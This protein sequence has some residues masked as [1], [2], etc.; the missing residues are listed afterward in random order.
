METASK[1]ENKADQ[2]KQQVFYR[3]ICP[4]YG[5]GHIQLESEAEELH[6]RLQ[7]LKIL[8]SDPLQE[9]S[10]DEGDLDYNPAHDSSR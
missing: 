10:D 1:T 3:Q 9:K 6:K 4:N 2:T 5:W 7:N 8:K